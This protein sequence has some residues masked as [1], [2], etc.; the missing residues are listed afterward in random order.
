[1]IAI[2]GLVGAVLSGAMAFYRTRHVRLSSHLLQQGA[3]YGA[4][5]G[6]ILYLAVGDSHSAAM[7]QST[8]NIK[9]IGDQDYDVEVTQSPLPVVVDFYASWCGPCKQLASVMDRLAGEFKGQVKFIKVNVDDSPALA[10]RFQV[11]AIPALV[12]ITNGA[13]KNTVVGLTSTKAL[14]EQMRGLVARPTP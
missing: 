7:N 3:V 2:G 1:M 12:F 8:E 9:K 11:Q 6:M 4:C 10:S 13:V 14:R 5:A